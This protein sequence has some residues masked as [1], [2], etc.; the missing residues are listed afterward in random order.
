L[1]PGSGALLSCNT[2]TTQEQPDCSILLKMVIRDGREQQSELDESN[3][4]LFPRFSVDQVK[5]AL[6]DTPVVM[7][8]GP[9][10]CGKTTLVRG[11]TSH[12]YITLDDAMSRCRNHCVT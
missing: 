10:Q 5:A 2:I 7:I 1:F 4:K 6:I 12:R 11:F 3:T 9:R 8:T